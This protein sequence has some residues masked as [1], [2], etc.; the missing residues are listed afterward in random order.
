MAGLAAG[1]SVWLSALLPAFVPTLAASLQA[2]PP[3][4]HWLTPDGLLGLGGWYRLGRAVTVSLV[5]NVARSEEHT[6]E[7]QSLIR[8][9]YAFFCLKKLNH[10]FQSAC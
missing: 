6:S 10:K 1:T 2:V 8:H 3:G 9:P 7:L 4:L 5:V